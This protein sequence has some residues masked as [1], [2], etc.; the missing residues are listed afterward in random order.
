MK[1]DAEDK[2]TVEDLIKDCES[3]GQKA[4]TEQTKLIEVEG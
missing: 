4:E 1:P 2:Q 3:F